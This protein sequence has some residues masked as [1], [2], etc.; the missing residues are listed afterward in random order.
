MLLEHS[1]ATIKVNE[2][3]EDIYRIALIL[4]KRLVPDLVRPII[5]HANLFVDQISTID[6]YMVVRAANSPAVCLQSAPIVASSRSRAPICQV[7]FTVVSKDQGYAA[8]PGAGAWTWFTAGILRNGSKEVVQ[9]RVICWNVT[10]IA[11]FNPQHE[12]WSSRSK[13]QEESAWVRM[14]RDGDQI[15]IR[16]HAQFVGWINFVNFVQVTVSSKVIV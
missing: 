1:Q 16:G 5:E 8:Y 12:R 11:D 14:L 3:Q 15:V 13:D 6:H 4:R 7:D 9:E 10:E 2:Q